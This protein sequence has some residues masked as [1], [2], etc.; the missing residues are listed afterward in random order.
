[1]PRPCSVKTM[2]SA[3]SAAMARRTVIGLTA[4]A[5]QSSASEGRRSP[6]RYSP[7]A[8][9]SRTVRASCA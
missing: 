9:R 6:G 7:R 8:M 1:M 2:S 5:A 4:N 3:T